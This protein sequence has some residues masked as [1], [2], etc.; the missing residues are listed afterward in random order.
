MHRCKNKNNANRHHPDDSFSSNSQL[1]N[2]KCGGTPVSN[3]INEPETSHR[4]LIRKSTWSAMGDHTKVVSKSHQKSGVFEFVIKGPNPVLGI[5][6]SALGTAHGCCF[7]IAEKLQFSKS[8]TTINFCLFTIL[9]AFINGSKLS[10]PQPK[11][12]RKLIMKLMYAIPD[13]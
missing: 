8:Q 13:K 7:F 5:K 1:L 9:S 11:T 3:P 2:T 12:T 6:H 4:Y 10:S